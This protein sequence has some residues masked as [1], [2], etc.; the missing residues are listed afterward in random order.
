LATDRNRMRILNS[1]S[2]KKD[3][4]DVGSPGEWDDWTVPRGR[5]VAVRIRSIELINFLWEPGPAAGAFESAES[6]DMVIHFEN[7]KEPYRCSPARPDEAY[8]LFCSLEDGCF[9]DDPFLSF[10]DSDE[11]LVAFDARKVVYIEAPSRLIDAGRKMVEEPEI[12][13]SPPT[14]GPTQTYKRSSRSQRRR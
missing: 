12:G 9:E 8:L 2:F 13:T 11:E 4:P 14:D 3:E 6:G 10:T 1:H 5:E 7:R